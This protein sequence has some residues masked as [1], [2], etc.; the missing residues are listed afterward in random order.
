LD[1]ADI[2]LNGDDDNPGAQEISLQATLILDEQSPDRI[3]DLRAQTYNGG[4]VQSSIYAIQVDVVN[5]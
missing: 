5:N 4:A 1:R 2:R 3:V